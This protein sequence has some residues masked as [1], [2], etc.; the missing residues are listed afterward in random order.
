MP[1][2]FERGSHPRTSGPRI[3]AVKPAIKLGGM[4]SFWMNL[5]LARRSF[6]NK[7]RIDTRPISIN[8]VQ[9][10]NVSIGGYLGVNWLLKASKRFSAPSLYVLTKDRSKPFVLNSFT[11]VS[12]GLNSAFSALRTFGRISFLRVLMSM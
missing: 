2:L 8:K 10:V 7:R 6:P 9:G 12:A 3:N 5:T 1:K 4:N 11:R